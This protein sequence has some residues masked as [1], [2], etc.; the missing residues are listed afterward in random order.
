[1]EDLVIVGFGGHAKSMADCIERKRKYN[2]V[3]YTDIKEHH[4]KYKYLGTDNELQSIFDSG[5][6]YAAVGIGYMG[7]GTIRNK[8][9]ELLKSIGYELPVITDPTSIISDSAIIGEGTFVGKA[10]IINAEASIGKMSIIN[11]RALVEHECKIGEFTHVAVGAV[12][13]GQVVVGDS[14]LVGANATVIQCRKIESNSIVPA[15]VT[16]R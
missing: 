14:V 5:V 7:K 6:R 8:V 15:G 1:M 10:A 12:L 3:G 2:V 4:S 13:C 11:T 16:I 9:F